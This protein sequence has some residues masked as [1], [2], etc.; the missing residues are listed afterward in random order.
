MWSTCRDIVEGIGHFG[1]PLEFRN[2]KLVSKS[3]YKWLD[4]GLKFWQNASLQT[5]HACYLLFKLHQNLFL[6]G[7]AGTGKSFTLRRMLALAEKF[8]KRVAITATTGLA[9]TSFEGGCTI[10]SFSCLGTGTVPLEKLL[11]EYETTG[12]VR[13]GM[14]WRSIDILLLDECSMLRSD[15]LEK[16]DAMAKL[17]RGCEKKAFGGLQVVMAGDFLQLPP[18]GSTFAF[19]AAAWQK[20]N[21]IK[22]DLTTPVRQHQDPSYYS[23]LDRIRKG[24]H[25]PLDI[26]KLQTRTFSKAELDA[27]Y[28]SNPGA[29]VKPTQIY[30]KNKEMKA[31]NDE[32]FAKLTTPID[33]QTVAQDTIHE[34]VK[35]GK[36]Y[37]YLPS[38]KI[39]MPEAHKRLESHLIRRSPDLIQFRRGAQ[40]ILTINLNVKF[41]L[42]N[43][44][45]C[46]YLGNQ[47][48]EFPGC[49][50]PSK[51]MNIALHEFFLPIPKTNN[52][53]L[54]RIQ[55]PLRLGYA[56]TTH[57]SQ[58]MSLD[59]AI[60]DIGKDVFTASQ[61]YVALSRVR[62]LQALHLIGFDE[63]RI[64]ANPKALAFYGYGPS[65]GTGSRNNKR[66]RPI[67]VD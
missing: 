43:G 20:L 8:R 61:A 1:A 38:A 49:T 46:V 44:S 30:C 29:Q 67:E 2:L 7:S 16:L 33:H 19:E 65:L 24:Q 45:R 34:K 3:Y 9:A 31:M 37:Q 51:R 40:Y 12:R 13:G 28:D 48:F 55:L 5:E 41:K 36:T 50:G 22:L 54:K 62:T 26:A 58:G 32:E 6:T 23:L 17:A 15:L 18:I 52:L 21:M 42:C 66:M 4:D 57:G 59:S 10:H 39:A 35:V 11:Q 64:T 47:L 27:K 25:T 60:V 14:N 63:S 53:F 56:I